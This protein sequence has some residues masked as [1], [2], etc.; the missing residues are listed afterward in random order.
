MERTML[1]GRRLLGTLVLSLG[2][3]A[4]H[5]PA[6]A[7]AAPPVPA[8][9]GEAAGTLQAGKASVELKYAYAL[10]QDDAYH[11]MLT[12]APVPAD[13]LARELKLGGGQT[14]LRQKKA[15]GVF[16]IVA[17]DGFVRTLIPFVGDDLRGGSSMASVGRLDSFAAT[18]SAATG[19][20]Q[21]ALA[22]TMGQGWSYGASFNAALVKP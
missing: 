8:K 18:P 7:Q 15:S 3:C 22:Q 10:A 5:T 11:V 9:I 2:L 20:G 1:A 12:D 21:R 16:M 13:M 17:K 6:F 14:M 19:Q 4:L